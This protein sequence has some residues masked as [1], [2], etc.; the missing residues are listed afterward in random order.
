M[1][2]PGYDEAPMKR[3]KLEHPCLNWLQYRFFTGDGR[4]YPVTVTERLEMSESDNMYDNTV[5]RAF[6]ESLGFELPDEVFS[7]Q[8]DGS[9]IVFTLQMVEEV[10][11]DFRIFEQQEK[12]PLSDEQVAKL[13]EA[14]YYRPEG[15]MIL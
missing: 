8:I 1:P 10:G 7:F 15:F 2:L 6:I 12:F 5:P 11:C 14:G 4:P 13:K 3:Q 9:D